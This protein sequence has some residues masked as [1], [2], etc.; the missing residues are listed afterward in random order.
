MLMAQS[1][2]SKAPEAALQDVPLP[3]RNPKRLEPPP[4]PHP[5][6]VSAPEW[7]AQEVQAALDR[8]DMLLSDIGVDYTPADPIREGVCGTPAPIELRSIGKNQKVSVTPPARVTCGLA[9]TLNAWADTVLQPEARKHLGSNIVS[10]RNVASYV[11]RNRYNAPGKRISEHARAN[12]LDMAAFKTADGQ[13]VT[14]RD[15]WALPPEKTEAQDKPA[16]SAPS[17]PAA[18]KPPETGVVHTEAD[19]GPAGSEADTASGKAEE[20]SD[21]PAEKPPY[22]PESAFLYAIHEGA[23]K[24]FGTVLGPL[25]NEAHKDHFHYDLAPRKHSNYCE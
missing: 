12:A 20:E 18:N 19:P 6:D 24:L 13:T 15:D 3:K 9:A 11:C 21:G 16:A 5:R 8:C 2:P 1:T 4:P 10:I 23:C 7:S 17:E 22:R 25:A 14:V